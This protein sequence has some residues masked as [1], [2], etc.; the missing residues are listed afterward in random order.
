MIRQ[1]FVCPDYLLNCIGLKLLQLLQH[2]VHFLHFLFCQLIVL[3]Y[4]I[5]LL[6][7]ASFVVLA[8][9]DLLH[10][11]VINSFDVDMNRRNYCYCFMFLWCTWYNLKYLTQSK[12]FRYNTCFKQGFPWHSKC[13]FTLKHVCDMIIT[14][15]DNLGWQVKHFV[16]KNFS[17]YFKSTKGKLCSHFC[18]E[19][20]IRKVAESLYIFL[21]TLF[22]TTQ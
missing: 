14:Y 13:K 5:I 19:Q 15:S 21:T 8:Y 18:E 20:N 4:Q 1:T 9:V 10:W 6:F 7:Q 17:K 3:C 11:S 22:L 16:V 12:K 2:L